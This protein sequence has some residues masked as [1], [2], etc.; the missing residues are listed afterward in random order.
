ML[1]EEQRAE[2]RAN[3]GAYHLALHPNYQWVSFQQEFIVPAL[4]QVAEH[5]I[6]ALM[7]LMPFRHSKTDLG[8]LSFHSWLFGR[9]P[10]RKNMLLSYSDKFAKRFGGKILTN[11]KSDAHREIFP[12]SIPSRQA[13][14]GS[15]FTTTAGGEFFSAG[16]GGT[17]TGQGVDGVLGIDDPIKNIDEARSKTVIKSRMDDYDTAVNTRLEGG[18]RV[19]CTNRWCKGD[20]VDRLLDA[21]G[22][23]HEGGEWTVLKIPAEAGEEDPLGR[24]PGEFLWEQRLGKYWYLRHKRK[25][26]VWMPMCQQEPQADKGKFFKRDWLLFYQRPIKPGKYPAY[27]ITDSARGQEKT[28]DRSVIGVFVTTPEKRLMLADAAVGRFDPD[29]LAD[30][31]MRL[32]KK[33]KPRRWIYEELGLNSDTWHLNKRAKK[34]NIRIHAVP[35]GRKGPRHMMSKETRI[36]ELIPDWREGRIWLPDIYG[37]AGRAP[38]PFASMKIDENDEEEINIV[39]YFIDHEYLEYAGEGS[40]EFDDMLDMFSRLHEPELQ[41]SYPAAASVDMTSQFVRSRR[42]QRA[43]SWES[44]L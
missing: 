30:H 25:T 15:Y 34:E 33:W 10:G 29:E 2:A 1:T 12:E 8:T 3:L 26:R 39:Q 31:H 11:I 18:S 38:V 19:L 40:V 43:G 4:H 5:Q 24:A 9:W 7:I 20:F 42:L 21:E 17:I 16:F 14:S 6:E 23:T 44:V 36:E 41:L 28:H 22:E 35:V 32:L 37:E 27:M 13:Q